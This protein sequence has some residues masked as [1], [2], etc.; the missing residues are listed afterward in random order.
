MNTKLSSLEH[1]Y[2]LCRLKTTRYHRPLKSTPFTQQQPAVIRKWRK[3]S[4]CPLTSEEAILTRWLSPVAV[5]APLS[6][7]HP[8]VAV[9]RKGRLGVCWCV[10]RAGPHAMGRFFFFD[11]SA[12]SLQENRLQGNMGRESSILVRAG[13]FY[14]Y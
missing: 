11:Y 2:R 8:S 3:S 5:G 4:V 14:S 10:G 1:E 13:H 7:S 12:F 6:A 9:S